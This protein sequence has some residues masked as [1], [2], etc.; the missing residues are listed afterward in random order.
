MAYDALNQETTR[1]V[2]DNPAVAG[3]YARPLTS[4]YD[5]LGEVLTRAAEGQTITTV[6]DLAGCV[7]TTT[8]SYNGNNYLVDVTFDAAG[9]RTGMTWP[10]GGSLTY[11]Y[12][13][14]N[15]MDL[16][17]DNN[18]SVQLANY[19]YDQLSRRDLVTFGNG[20]VSDP[21]YFPDSA[22]LALSH[23]IPGGNRGPTVAIASTRSR[24][25]G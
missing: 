16:V 25:S 18:G 13:A 7:D 1:T 21:A 11:T 4:T 15:R 12:D 20:A 23:T 14:L 17:T 8:D 3:N 24:R 5:L 6:Y 22:L 10:G 2:P 19:D 9:N